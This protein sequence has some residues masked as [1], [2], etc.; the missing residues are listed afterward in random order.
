MMG[1]S[2]HCI[3]LIPNDLA[4]GTIQTISRG[5]DLDEAGLT[6]ALTA[7]EMARRSDSESYANEDTYILTGSTALG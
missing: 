6:A 4:L 7:N 5:A 1:I 3:Q 2:I